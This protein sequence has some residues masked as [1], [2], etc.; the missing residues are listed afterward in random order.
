METRTLEQIK[1]Y[2]L[3]LN[4]MFS[5][6]ENSNLV[7]FAYS[8][9][10]LMDWYDSFKTDVYQDGDYH[11][12]FQKESPLYNYNPIEWGDHCGVSAEWTTRE[13]L[14]EYVAE[15]NNSFGFMAVPQLV[16]CEDL[17]YCV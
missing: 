11:K 14:S 15:C 6:F 4:S 17:L 10:E 9:Q 7:A 12:T 16:G 2:S 3:H 5:N 13:A 8:E 1:I